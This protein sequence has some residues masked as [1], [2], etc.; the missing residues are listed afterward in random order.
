MDATESTEKPNA[1]KTEFQQWT[2]CTIRLYFSTLMTF[3]R[4]R[5]LNF[6]RMMILSRLAH[7]QHCSVSDIS[8]QMEISAPAASQ[9]LD[10]LVEAGYVS[11][12]ENSEDRRIRN[13]DITPKGL[14]L[15][16]EIKKGPQ[17]KIN[18]IIDAIPPEERE[19]V[20]K[21]LHTLNTIVT[22]SQFSEF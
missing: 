7:E 15:V 18:T 4:S 13:I 3:V 14:E 21:S 6:P 12:S 19:Q 10:K 22:H 17:E 20:R 5:N 8:R 16:D 11:R 1:L 2:E 9:L